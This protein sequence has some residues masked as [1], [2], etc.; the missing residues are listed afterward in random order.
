MFGFES[1]KLMSLC[2]SSSKNMF[3]YGGGTGWVVA[4]IIQK[5]ACLILPVIIYNVLAEHF[6]CLAFC[7]AKHRGAYGSAG[8]ISC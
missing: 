1:S 3:V 2:L 4:E 8:K 7:C 6:V 5:I